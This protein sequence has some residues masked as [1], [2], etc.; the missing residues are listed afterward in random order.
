MARRETHQEM[1]ANVNFLRRT[2]TIGLQ[3]TIDSRINSV[4]GRRSSSQSFYRWTVVHS[5][6]VEGGGAKIKVGSRD[7][8]L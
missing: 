5:T 4:S 2:R 3:N 1:R 8:G 7:L 6:D